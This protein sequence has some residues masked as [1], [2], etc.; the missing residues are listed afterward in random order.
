MSNPGTS[1]SRKLCIRIMWLAVPAFILALGLF[2]LQSRYLIRKEA[3]G[4]SNSILQAAIQRVSNYTR[5][6]E[7]S[8]NANAWLLEESFRPDSL[9]AISQRVVR[10]NPH[11]ISCS[12][13]AAPNVFPQYGKYFSVYTVKEGDAVTS[14]IDTEYEYADKSWYKTPCWRVKP[15]G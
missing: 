1:L 3:I 5:T 14:V 10:L 4:R 2:Y 9:Q 12:V 11:I 6:I 13:S 7:V 8:V 15:V